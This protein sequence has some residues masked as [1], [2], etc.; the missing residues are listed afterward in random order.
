METTDVL[1]IGG[2]AAGLVVAST[3]KSHYP[4]KDFLVVRKDKQAMIP[5][6]IPYIFGTV[7]STDK[8]IMPDALATNSGARVLIDEV[9]S[10]DKEN[11][12]CKT[13]ND[14]E[15]RFEKLV[16]ATGSTPILSPNG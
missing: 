12:V 16:L 2:S 3:G 5:C 6:G 8:N 13:K 14:K 9:I 7:E 4:D 1:V 10:I 11:N 15:I